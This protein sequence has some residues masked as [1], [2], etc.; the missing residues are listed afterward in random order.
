M[1]ALKPPFTSN[2]INIQNNLDIKNKSQLK[3][4]NLI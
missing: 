4:V 1:V 3:T 2:E